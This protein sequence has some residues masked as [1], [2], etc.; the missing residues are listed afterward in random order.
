M[1]N[2][3]LSEFTV[4][5]RYSND[6][7]RFT[8]EVQNLGGIRPSLDETGNLRYIAIMT[9]TES[10][11]GSYSDNP[12]HDR[13][14]GDI[15]IYTAQGKSDN[16]LLSGRNKRILEQYHH[17]V[18]FFGFVNHG[19]QMYEFLGM[20]ELIRHY[21]EHQLDDKK[22]LRNVWVFEFRIHKTVKNIPIPLASEITKSLI[23]DNRKSSTI[24]LD[25][26]VVESNSISNNLFFV[27]DFR[28]KLFNINPFKFEHLIKIVLEKRGFVNASVTKASGDGG[29]D[30]SAI[31]GKLDVFF[32]GTLVQFQAKRWRHS[33]GSIE[34]NNFRGA[35]SSNA[36]GIF[37]TTSNYTRGAINNAYHQSKSCVSLIDGLQFSSLAIETG[38]SVNDLSS[39]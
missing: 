18:P 1:H 3:N 21:S 30:L 36:K 9:S 19:Y 31:V 26:E 7:I 22:C 28:S 38:I 34:I 35:L 10:A 17:P 12:Y 5:D 32:G 25:R 14:E 16:Q 37:I 6:Q 13:V 11:R 8:L 33:V 27:E 20:L 23:S 4:G 24:E 39:L 2:N 15:L 29:I